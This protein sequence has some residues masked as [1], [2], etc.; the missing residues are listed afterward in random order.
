MKPT[1]VTDSKLDL[2]LRSSSA[3]M[4]TSVM[5][6]SVALSRWAP[7]VRSIWPASVKQLCFEHLRQG[8]V[9]DLS[10]SIGVEKRHYVA[11]LNADEMLPDRVVCLEEDQ[12]NIL[13][14]DLPVEKKGEK[15]EPYETGELGEP[16]CEKARSSRGR[17]RT[18]EEKEW[19]PKSAEAVEADCQGHPAPGQ[20]QDTFRE[21]D[22]RS[23]FLNHDLKKW[24]LARRIE[25]TIRILLSKVGERLA[26]AA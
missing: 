17:S 14:Q 8:H 3:T 13:P 5:A 15:E 26:S 24:C 11:V 25:K 16:E 12:K 18:G 4:Q 19:R 9:A 21:K 6:N 10:G 22:T 23:T 1:R 7:G 2:P 20:G